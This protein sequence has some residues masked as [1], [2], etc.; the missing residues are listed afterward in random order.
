MSESSISQKIGRNLLPYGTSPSPS[1]S[2]SPSSSASS[3]SVIFGW[4]ITQSVRA[5]ISGRAAHAAAGRR[6]KELALYGAFETHLVNGVTLGNQTSFCY[7]VRCRKCSELYQNCAQYFSSQ[8]DFRFSVYKLDTMYNPRLPRRH[9]R[10]AYQPRCNSY[11]PCVASF[12]F[13][14]KLDRISTTISER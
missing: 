4:Y 9:V 8:Q 14:D 1:P 2:P 10:H 11:T 13:L 12:R 7:A 3:L 5:T 6:R